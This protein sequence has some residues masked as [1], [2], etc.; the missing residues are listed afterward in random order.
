MAG[1]QVGSQLN[2]LYMSNRRK[3]EELD[4][5]L[6]LVE[7]DLE[8]LSKREFKLYFAVDFQQIF[9][10]AFPISVFVPQ[11]GA[12]VPEITKRTKRI[13]THIAR[14]FIFYGL[15]PRPV[16]LPPHASELDI[17]L[18]LFVT[19]Q[20]TFEIEFHT[21]KEWGDTHFSNK[22]RKL[23]EKANKWFRENPQGDPTGERWYRQLV[24]FLYNNYRDMLYLTTGLITHGTKI[25][26]D[27]LYSSKP[28]LYFCK[29]TFPEYHNIVRHVVGSRVS[30]WFDMFQ[31]IRGKW[32][33]DIRDSK[34]IEIVCAL[35]EEFAKENENRRI[36]LISDAPSMYK[37]LNWDIASQIGDEYRKEFREKRYPVGT[38]KLAEDEIRLL[39]EIEVFLV[40]LLHR[41]SNH[42]ETLKKIRDSKAIVNGY[43]ALED[44]FSEIRE[45][46][47]MSQYAC[48]ICEPPEECRD[49][50][51]KFSTAIGFYENLQNMELLVREKRDMIM[52]PY[53]IFLKANVNFEKSIRSIV[54]FLV[55]KSD[56]FEKMVRDEKHK[57]EEEFDKLVNNIQE[58][59]QDISRELFLGMGHRL[60][61]IGG[62]PYRIKFRKEIS[63][64][65]SDLIR[66]VFKEEGNIDIEEIRGKSKLLMEFCDDPTI[67]EDRFLLTA[68]LCY[69]YGRY[70]EAIRIVEDRLK[71]EDCKLRSEYIY[72]KT[73]S[74]LNLAIG[75]RNKNAFERALKEAISA[76]DEYGIKKDDLRFLNLKAAVILEGVGN[77]LKE[78][79]NINEAINLLWDTLEKIE[80]P[81]SIGKDGEDLKFSLINN[82]VYGIVLKDMMYGTI[83]GE[84][85]NAYEKMD[86]LSIEFKDLHNYPD[87]EDTRVWSIIMQMKYSDD[88]IVIKDLYKE[89]KEII[90]DVLE[91][92]EKRR[93]TPYK[94]QSYSKTL[95]KLEE[96]HNKKIPW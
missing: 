63:N 13:N 2:K 46:C 43:L 23:I 30:R 90:R 72:V 42:A 26:N 96:M 10:F 35:N 87:I 71:E 56:S 51:K 64:L 18:D 12:P 79:L 11:P 21:L 54:D 3:F 44:R 89:G 91:L 61:R 9:E 85:E 37:V 33:S 38:F 92:S 50:L 95:E 27:L 62:I 65:I 52:K 67:G 15:Q 14:A 31:N 78:D 76:Y 94:I 80:K 34:A 66:A 70:N 83:K 93:M 22:E 53:E 47:E 6:Q 36:F 41:E 73:I 17:M 57:F 4:I 29:D 24:R 48:D 75:Q 1:K 84:Q 7:K 77:S 60:A 74:H 40:F 32:L 39:R 59:V 8:F 20:I 28:K 88:E 69:C 68:V 82:Y 25:I 19:K 86:E 45:F 5:N 55:N 49:L 81:S 16:L 58:N